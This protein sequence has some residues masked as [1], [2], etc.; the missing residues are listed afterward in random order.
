VP[1]RD[2]LKHLAAPIRTGEGSTWVEGEIVA[3]PPVPGTQFRCVLFLPS[4]ADEDAGGAGTAVF[5]GRRVIRPTLLYAPRD[6]AGE[7]VALSAEDEVDV[8]AAE[9]NR[10]QG[11]PEGQAVRWLVQ[12]TPQ[13]F[14]K[15]GAEP[16]GFQATL[17]RIEE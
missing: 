10:V 7:Y 16:V 5:S 1:F 13:I 3:G 15:P 9:H 17:Q 6:L 8:I 14:G 4:P 2:V 12:G 11:I